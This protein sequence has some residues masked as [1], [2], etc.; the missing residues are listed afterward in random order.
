MVFLSKSSLSC[1]LQCPQKYKL[2]YVDNLQDVIPRSPQAQRGLNVHE[3]CFQSYDHLK[4]VSGSLVYDVDWVDEKLSLANGEESHF[5]RNFLQMEEERW[6]ICKEMAPKNPE[7]YFIPF[8]REKR[9]ENKGL[10][11]V[12][13]VD[14]VD[15]KFN[16]NFCVVDIKTEKPDYRPWRL[17]ELRREMAFYKILVEC[18][19][20]LPEGKCVEDFAI[21]YPHDNSVLYEK[22]STLTLTALRKNMG[23]MRGAIGR[24]DFPC[25]VTIY[26]RYCEC[27]NLGCPMTFEGKL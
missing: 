14:R 10:E 20:E 24:K 16:G 23:Y 8:M 5:L 15:K 13:I 9:L 17:T 12:G 18:S 3:F 21:Y 6:E 25:R 19:G 22:F 7:E 11:I 4:I 2:L 27:V 1:F 26:C